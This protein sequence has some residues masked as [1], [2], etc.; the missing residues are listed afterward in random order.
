MSPT[1]AIEEAAKIVGGKA[2]L[3]RLL[4]V[5]PPTVSQWCSGR[6][7]VPAA[8][9]A[10]IEELAGGKVSRSELCPD[11]PWQQLAS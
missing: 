10:R 7:P 9:A 8:R 3:A 2:V 5:R 1:E 11:F 6:R 4:K